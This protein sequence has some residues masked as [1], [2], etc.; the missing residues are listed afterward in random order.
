MFKK[1]RLITALALAFLS[2]P[3]YANANIS[4]SQNIS[5]T[6]I[7]S[8]AL[9]KVDFE[10]IVKEYGTPLY[11]YSEDKIRNNCRMFNEV[12]NENFGDSAK[13]LYASKAFS[14]P[15]LLKILNEENF[16]LDVVSAGELLAAKHANFPMQ[17]VVFHGN[18]KSL[19]EIELGLTLG[20]GKF[21]VDNLDEL[22]NIISFNKP[23]NVLLRIRPG[24]DGHIHTE[25]KTGNI[26]SKFGLSFSEAKEAISIIQNH[27]N[28]NLLGTHCHIGSQI[29]HNDS[30][31]K[32]VE[33][34]MDF[35]AEIR[36]EF[37]MTLNVLDLGGGFGVQIC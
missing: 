28:I 31:I 6:S 32:A 7:N 21:V 18:N 15:T 3:L 19:E 29:F 11:L 17:N 23:C 16:G 14:C 27:E 22:N 36:D 20:V 25:I 35:L 26:D 37:G 33:V 13:C 4:S 5:E 12:L 30:Y 10:Q 24:I 2:F 1:F 9:E 8:S 34:M